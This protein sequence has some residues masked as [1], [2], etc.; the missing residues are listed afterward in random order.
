MI[1]DCHS[2]ILSLTL[3]RCASLKHEHCCQVLSDGTKQQSMAMK[4]G[5]Y[6]VGRKSLYVDPCVQFGFAFTYIFYLRW[7]TLLTLCEASVFLLS[8]FFSFSI[9]TFPFMICSLQDK[10]ILRLF[11]KPLLF[12]CRRGDSG[13]G[14]GLGGVLLAQQDRVSNF[15][16]L[17]CLREHPGF[18]QYPLHWNGGGGGKGGL[19]LPGPSFSYQWTNSALI[20]ET[21]EL[22]FGP[23]K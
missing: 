8:L 7:L 11:C 21:W 23:N 6:V 15:H 19:K 2:H 1:L 14:W 10:K 22:L 4:A 12:Q 3:A 5:V 18:Y 17:K 9:I 20:A 16:F 13:P